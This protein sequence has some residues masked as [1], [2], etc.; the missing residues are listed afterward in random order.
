MLQIKY[1]GFLI[2]FE[3]GEGGGKTTQSIRLRKKLLELDREVITLREPGGTAISEQIR[4]VALSPDNIGMEFSTEVLLFQAAR[5]QLY[6][7][8]VIPSLEVGKIVVMDR[9]RDSSVVYQGMVRGFG[10]K[11]IESLNNLSTDNIFPDLTYLLDLPVDLGLKRRVD[12]GKMDRLDMEAR[13]FHQQ[14]R[15]AYLQL[16]KEDAANRW[17]IINAEQKLEQV[18]KD[19]WTEVENRLFKKNDSQKSD[20]GKKIPCYLDEK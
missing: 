12:S 1:P 2:T 7:E 9:S 16:A 15:E 17:V 20:S 8:I 13:E 11:I 3:G 10:R 5:A 18:E 19:I 4:Q 14:V 6:H